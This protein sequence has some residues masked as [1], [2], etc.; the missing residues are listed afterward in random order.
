MSVGVVLG[1]AVGAIVSKKYWGFYFARPAVPEI[2]S[3]TRVLSGSAVHAAASGDGCTLRQE[4][5]LGVKGADWRYLDNPV[6]QGPIDLWSRGLL[7][8]ETPP[9]DWL[10]ANTLYDAVRRSGVLVKHDIG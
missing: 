3:A 9:P 4:R 2:E 10:D 5:N 1:L 7:T 6:L 8:D